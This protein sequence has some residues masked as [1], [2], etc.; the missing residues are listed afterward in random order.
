MT[1][2]RVTEQEFE[3]EAYTLAEAQRL[4]RAR[5]PEGLELV[6]QRILSDGTPKT[7]RAIAPTVDQAVEEARQQI[8]ADST[9]LNTVILEQPGEGVAGADAF[10][11]EEARAAIGKGLKAGASV[12]SVQLTLPG[13]KGLL[14][15]GKKPGRYEATISQQAVVE[16]THTTKARI[17]ARIG[18]SPKRMLADNASSWGLAPS[19]VCDI[20]NT[21]L[22]GGTPGTA[23]VPNA[24]FRRLVQMGYNPYQ[25]GRAG[26]FG[27]AFGISSNDQYVHWKVMVFRDT[28]DWGLCRACT[29]D[30]RQFLGRG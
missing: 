29:E 19:G 3:I 30:V 25:T 17:E 28:T 24:Q 26:E 7:V 14:G 6:H 4:A 27:A 9:I 22:D 20:C 10:S 11:D 21:S 23:R 12:R 13:K 18:K 16:L 8:P 2:H 5:V 15:M 1:D